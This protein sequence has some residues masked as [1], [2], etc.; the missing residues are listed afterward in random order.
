MGLGM[1]ALGERGSSEDA[2]YGGMLQSVQLIT[3]LPLSAIAGFIG[4]SFLNVCSRP[5]NKFRTGKL[6]Q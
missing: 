4:I 1:P 2:G 3:Q 5:F 6:E